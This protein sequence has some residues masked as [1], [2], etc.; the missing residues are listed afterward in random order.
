MGD[1]VCHIQC[2]D[3]L[4]NTLEITGNNFYHRFNNHVAHRVAIS[5]LTTEKSE[6]ENADFYL[7]NCLTKKQFSS[8]AI[9][10]HE[11]RKMT[12]IFTNE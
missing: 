12:K 6:A 7:N 11:R 5:D 9:F 8:E 1:F 4:P 3:I 10:F 2:I